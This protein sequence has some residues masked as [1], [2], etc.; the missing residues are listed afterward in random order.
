MRDVEGFPPVRSG[1]FH[2]AGVI[3]AV[4]DVTSRSEA[5][6]EVQ[7]DGD[8]RVEMRGDGSEDGLVR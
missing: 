2:G 8:S 4:L 1:T 7:A 3:D 5:W 6:L